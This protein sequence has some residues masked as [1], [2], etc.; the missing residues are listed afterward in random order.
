M[1]KNILNCTPITNR[2]DSNEVIG[3]KDDKLLSELMEIHSRI[4]KLKYVSND[5]ACDVYLIEMSP[6]HLNWIDGPRTGGTT[7]GGKTIFMHCR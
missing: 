5:N 4:T 7:I 2:V 1:N 3:L 6:F